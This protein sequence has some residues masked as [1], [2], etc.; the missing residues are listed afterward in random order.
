MGCRLA[1]EEEA[2]H[3]DVRPWGKKGKGHELQEKK[4]RERGKEEPIASTLS[5]RIDDCSVNKR[6]G[7][8]ELPS[9]EASGEK[10][11][12]EGKERKGPRGAGSPGS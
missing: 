7:K 4:D 1:G 3:H 12:A 6:R 9:H 8:E 10:V 5:A 11:P 2:H